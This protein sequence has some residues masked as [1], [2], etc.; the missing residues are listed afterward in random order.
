MN[1]FDQFDQKSN[2]FDAFDAPPK[3]AKLGVESFKDIL[4]EEVKGK[5]WFTRN[6]IGAGTALSDVYEGIKQFA[7]S[8]DRAQIEA[9]RVFSEEAP[10][11]SIGGN[12]LL[13]ATPFGVAGGG[14]KGAAL[15]GGTFGAIQPVAGEQTAENIAKGKAASAAIGA[16][17]GAG[18]QKLADYAGQKIADKV[19][20][21]QFAKNQNQ[22]R[23][24]LV[25]E[26]QAAGLVIPPSMVNP[27]FKNVAIES[28]GGKIATQQAA[29]SK[30]ERVIEQLARKSLGLADDAELSPEAL[31]VFRSDVF[32]RAYGPVA[33]SGT[34]TTDTAYKKALDDIINKFVTTEKDFPT[35][36]SNPVVDMITGKGAGGLQ[37]GSFD[38]GIGVKKVQL[39]RD[40]A[41]EAFSKGDKELGKAMRAAAGAIED[42]LERHIASFGA[43]A[44]AR[45]LL[46][47]FRE[48][49]KL[50]AKSYTVEKS[51][52]AGSNAV[53]ARRLAADKRKGKPLEGELD[54]I[55][56]FASSFPKAAQPAAQVQGAGV[57]ALNAGL[58]TLLGS[59]GAIAG[60]VPGA[61]AAGI[62]FVARPAARAYSLS[63]GSQNAL[64][65][66]YELGLA[67]RSLKGFLPYSALGSN[68]AALES[69]D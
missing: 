61:L 10:V 21:N 53:D 63:K 64:R 49:R 41:S 54:L 47:Q 62:P 52:T 34:V 66:L 4:R 9:N 17:A 20:Q 13:A 1:P 15:A 40:Q 42:Q 22:S 12:V 25:E 48:G 8:G 44:E 35:G 6:L 5:D 18:G 55:A 29:S 27:S 50:L 7:G 24:R 58:A 51:L 23:D 30:N 38:A 2:P 46:R 67:E 37:V 31:K 32:N 33:N 11:G 59:G 60:G 16:V 45:E 3:P 69:L 56:K 26:A 19:L 14:V 39:L 43:G 28:V 68:V 36:A 65:D 57:S